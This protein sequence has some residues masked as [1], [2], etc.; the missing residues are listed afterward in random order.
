MDDLERAQNEELEKIKK[1]ALRSILTKEAMERLGRVKLVNPLLTQQI[2]LYL[3]QLFQTGQ[4]KERID[5]AKLREILTLLS[6]K[7]KW[8]I[9]RR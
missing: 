5:D 2:E 9:K 8:N 6:E 7:K 4:V 3:L 1:E